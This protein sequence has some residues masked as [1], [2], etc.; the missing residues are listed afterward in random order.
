MKGLFEK[1][2]PNSRSK[3]IFDKISAIGFISE[4]TYENYEIISE[5][6]VCCNPQF[7]DNKKDFIE[8]FP[9]KEIKKIFCRKIQ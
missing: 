8:K 7:F 1:E 3:D 2:H 4:S 5:M 6:M 9:F